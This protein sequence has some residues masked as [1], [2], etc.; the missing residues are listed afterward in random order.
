MARSANNFDPEVEAR[1]WASPFPSLET[2]DDLAAFL[3]PVISAAYYRG[4]A[5]PRA[6]VERVTEAWRVDIRKRE[7]ARA[8]ADELRARLCLYGD[9]ED[10]KLIARLEA[11]E[12]DRDGAN[13]ARL[14]LAKDAHAALEAAG[15]SA[16]SVVEGVRELAARAA[17]L[18]A[19]LRRLHETAEAFS[20]AVFAE[21][22]TTEIVARGCALD[23]ALRDAAALA[24]EATNGSGTPKPSPAPA[25]PSLPAE[26]DR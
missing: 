26:S 25:A 7:E 8:E 9:P 24:V 23:A 6:E 21:A 20:A 4:A 11:V 12:R 3:A 10:D 1:E 22:K 16:A 2:E 13:E 17:G 5:A 19:R 15:V 14:R 18:E